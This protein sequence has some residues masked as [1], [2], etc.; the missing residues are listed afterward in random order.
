M[1]L[2]DL[3]AHFPLDSTI[4]CSSQNGRRLRSAK[5]DVNE[6]QRRSLKEGERRRRG[7]RQNGRNRHAA[8]RD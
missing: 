2:R 6:R 8:D 3:R 5:V 4:F 7:E 1:I